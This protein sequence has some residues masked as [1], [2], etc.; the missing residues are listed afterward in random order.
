M[1]Q[2]HDISIPLNPS[3]LR[4]L[5]FTVSTITFFNGTAPLSYLSERTK[6]IVRANPWLAGYLKRKK[7]GI[8]L[9]YS[10][11]HNE[12]EKT[13]FLTA[14]DTLLHESMSFDELSRRLR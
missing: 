8:C 11:T 7:E 2:E 1:E 3:D 9:C 14:T 13:L 4:F 5:K 6:L 10:A 12:N